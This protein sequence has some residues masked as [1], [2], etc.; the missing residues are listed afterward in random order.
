MNIYFLVQDSLVSKNNYCR[1]LLGRLNESLAKYG[2][3]LPVDARYN[4]LAVITLFMEKP[5]I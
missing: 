4:Y 5:A 1:D 2:S 3:R